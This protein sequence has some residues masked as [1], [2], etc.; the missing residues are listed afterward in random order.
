[1]VRAFLSIAIVLLA[2]GCPRRGAAPSDAG[3]GGPT[4]L[5]CD[6]A[7]CPDADRGAIPVDGGEITIHLDAE[8]AILCDLVEHDAYGRWIV[9]NQVQET[10]LF[11]DPWTGAIGP[12]LAE[13]WEETPEALTLHLRAGVTWH[14]GQPFTAADALFTLEKARDPKVGAD[15]RADL[16]P[17]RAVESPDP[18]TLVLRLG[19]PA[20]L[21]RQTLAHLAILPRHLYDGKDLRRAPTSRAPVGTGPFKF[22]RW[23]TGEELV[24]E[25]NPAYWGGKPHLQ[26]VTFRFIRDKAVALQLYRRGELDVMWRLPSPQAA[27]EVERDAALAGDRIFAWTPRAYYFVVWNTRRGPLGDARVRRALTMLTDRARFLQ[28]AFA[29]RARPVTGPYPLGTA[30]YAADVGAPPFDV[31]QARALLDEAGVKELSLTFLATT[32]SRTV[33][34]LATLMKEDFARAGVKLEV[35]SVDFPVLLERL[36]AHDFDVSA[37]QWTISLEQDNYNMFHSSQAAGGQN[38]GAWASPEADQLLDEIRR[39]AD[40]GARH[41]LD[42]ALHRLI[43]REQPYTFLGSPEVQTL[44]RGRVRG[45]TP[46]TDGF[47]LARA[48]VAPLAPPSPSPPPPP[49]PPSE[50]KRAP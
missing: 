3:G 41:Q 11:Q 14:D 30:S 39:T 28:I 44:V 20:P 50:A 6:G 49:S 32:G 24:L 4:V 33:E 12:R 46:S 34:Q 42:Q 48:W 18:Q 8:P 13:R 1:M 9:E 31:K 40:D 10:L 45:L 38:Y 37:L 17:V 23:K 2:A 35:A 36:R 21:L 5:R 15:Q 25:A 22:V 26:R 7:G 43:A 19:R 16:A 47:S 29:G 27:A